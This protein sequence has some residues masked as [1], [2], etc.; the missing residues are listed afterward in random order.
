MDNW[1]ARIGADFGAPGSTRRH[2]FM[3]SA[4]INAAFRTLF[5]PLRANI[6]RGLTN[7]GQLYALEMDGCVPGELLGTAWIPHRSRGIVDPT[8]LADTKQRRALF[9]ELLAEPRAEALFAYVHERISA[10]GEPQ[11]YVEIVSADGCFAA[12]HPIHKGTGWHSRE[13]S[14]AEHRRIDPRAL[15]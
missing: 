14:R 4:D 3:E 6:R 13:L 11:L 2:R 15:A 1:Q 12:A 10:A 5:R 9:D 8:L 7:D